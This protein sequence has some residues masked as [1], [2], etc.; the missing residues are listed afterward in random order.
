MESD[1]CQ[2]IQ[3]LNQRAEEKGRVEGRAEGRAEGKAEANAQTVKKLMQN[4]GMGLEE[5]MDAMGLSSSDREMIS[6]RE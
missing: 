5:A 4:L 1:V 3:T 2:A 6:V